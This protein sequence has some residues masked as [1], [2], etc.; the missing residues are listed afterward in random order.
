MARFCCVNFFASVDAD[1]N[2]E[3]SEAKMESKVMKRRSSLE[4]GGEGGTGDGNCL[5][6]HKSLD[7]GG[8]SNLQKSESEEKE[9]DKKD[10][11]LERRIRNKVSHR[12]CCLTFRIANEESSLF[13]QFLI[14]PNDH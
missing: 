5:R 9:K 1:A 4:S 6:R 2:E 13:S 11:R 10:P 12:S 14:R 3:G 8:Q 7:G